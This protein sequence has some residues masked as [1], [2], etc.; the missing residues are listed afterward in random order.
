MHPNLA[1]SYNNFA[2]L[3]MNIEKYLQAEEMLNK[4]L[5]IQ[6]QVYEP[7]HP[8]LASSYNTLRKLLMKTG[9][10][11]QAEEVLN[12]CLQIQEEVLNCILT[13]QIPILRLEAYL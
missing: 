2:V 6:E 7:M 1:I 9:E 8:H 3:L 12:R 10:Y 11:I 13:L 4:C 5:R